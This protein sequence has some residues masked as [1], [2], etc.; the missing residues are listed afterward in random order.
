M[1]AG[2]YEV[3]MPLYFPRDEREEQRA[4]FQ[5]PVSSG[6]GRCG[7]VGGRERGLGWMGKSCVGRR[8]I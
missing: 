5:L 7:V 8:W 4:R 3:L 2:I 6:A 1:D